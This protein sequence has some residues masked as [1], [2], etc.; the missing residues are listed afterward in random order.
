MKKGKR[1][2]AGIIGL[3]MVTCCLGTNTQG[4]RNSTPLYVSAGDGAEAKIE[5]FGQCGDNLTFSLYNTGDLFISGSGDMTD[6]QSMNDVPWSDSLKQIKGIFIE[7]G[8]T[9]I[10]NWAFCFSSASWIQIPST[11][12]RIG[13]RACSECAELTEIKIPE[14][15]TEI[16]RDA[17][18]NCPELLISGKSGTAAETYANEHGIAFDDP[19][20]LANKAVTWKIDE[21]GTLTISGKGA[22]VFKDS[23]SAPWSDYQDQI[24]SVV[25]ENGVTSISEKAFA[26]YSNLTSAV[27]ANSVTEIG[28]SAFYNCRNLTSVTLPDSLTSIESNTFNACTKLNTIIIPEHVTI[29]QDSAFALCAELRAVTFPKSVTEISSD[30]F[31]NCWGLATVIILNSECVIGENNFFE[32]S[33]I[34]GYENST[35]QAFAEKNKYSFE[36]ITPDMPVHD[37][38]AK[39]KC[40]DNLE[41][42]LDNAGTLTISGTGNMAFKKNSNSHTSGDAPWSRFNK[43]IRKVVIEEGV[44]TIDYYSFYRF[45]NLVSVTLPESLN[46]IA[47]SAFEACPVLTSINFPDS[48]T[49]IGEYAFSDCAS[50]SAV[51]IPDTVTDIGGKAFKGT[52]W[53]EA[54]KK[55]DPL[56]IVNHLLIDGTACTGD[57]VIPE[58]VTSICKYAFENAETVTSV[59]ISDSVKSVHSPA[60]P[61]CRR[62]TECKVSPDNPHLRSEDGVLFYKNYSS[63]LFYPPAKPDKEY[64]IPNGVRRITQEAFRDC[65]NLTSVVFSDGVNSIGMNAFRGCSRLRTVTFPDSLSSIEY[66]AFY[67]C[68]SLGSVTIPPKVDSIQSGAFEYCS[69]LN[70][71]TFMNPECSISN[72]TVVNRWKCSD[73]G[74]IIYESLIYTGMIYGYEGSTAQSYAE[75]NGCQFRIIGSAEPIRVLVAEGTCGDALTWTLD[76]EGCLSI[77]GNGRMYFGHD[78]PDF[79]AGDAPW[80]SYREKI[81]SVV[82]GE[83]VTSIDWYAFAECGNLATVTLSES[84]NEIRE[85]AFAYCPSLTAIVLP[86]GLTSI[87]NNLFD[88]CNS[89][90]YITIP[91]N[92]TS[93]GAYAFRDSLW[94]RNRRLENPLVTVNDVLVDGADSS[95]TIVIPDGVKQIGAYA[96]AGCSRLTSVTVPV[97]VE[98]IGDCAFCVCDQLES[99]T[100]LAPEC[101]IL[102][103]EKGTVEKPATICNRLGEEG[104]VFTGR[105]FGYGN[106][107]AQAYAKQN[108]FE[109]GMLDSN[110]SALGDVNNDGSINAKDANAILIAAAK[111]GTGKASGLTAELEIAADVNGDGTINA[112]DA[113]IVLRYAAAVGTGVTAK[114][115][116]YI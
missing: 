20:E 47:P 42:L 54:Q 105:I 107:T 70:S 10:G 48:V 114:I 85:G 108:G 51:R 3:C 18:K 73:N 21:D 84:V 102:A 4:Y 25:V 49:V 19:T 116:D 12:K 53:L 99:V 34:Y 95:G 7:E 97:S 1:I 71:V 13:Q 88:G 40:G 41:W 61:G 36:L 44:S 67:G 112:K 32:R 29:I 57:V 113:N 22:M 78:D 94:L 90:Y 31:K 66:D 65:V 76:S 28:E 58:S 30:A 106:S 75:K 69:A 37:M 115:T 89:L 43:Q 111:I 15:V 9:S 79:R 14:S 104:P 77:R 82:I 91:Q 110:P 96:F 62:L 100:I 39:G 81:Q 17:F 72:G 24:T 63:L 35:A 98:S 74:G 93:F 68:V 11:V 64:Q 60:F 46:Y 55:K 83:G 16:G 5:K 38:M 59:S 56:V 101:A 80:L 45:P 23:N 52:P 26:Q 8:V 103:P 2:T 87:P 27:I 6:F 109:F 92:V 50:L 86:S 33:T